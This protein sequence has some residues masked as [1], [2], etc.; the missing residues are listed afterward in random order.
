[1]PNAWITHVKEFSDKKKMKYND[2][3]KS[4]ECKDAYQSSKP[5]K[6]T[7]DIGVK[8]PKMKKS[9]KLSMDTPMAVMPPTEMMMPPMK[10]KRVKSKK[11][12]ME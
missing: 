9:D 1:M 2:A 7:K 6:E 11:V 4:Q 8:M 12:M 5:K 10:M 3:L